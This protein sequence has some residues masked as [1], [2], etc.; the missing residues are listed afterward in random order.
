L[1]APPLARIRPRLLYG[2]CG[3]SLLVVDPE[4]RVSGGLTGWYFRQ[5]RFLSA[6]ALELNGAR[7]YF[8]S[9]AEAAP[10][11]LELAYI[12]P[13][14][15]KGGGGGSGSGASGAR[16]GLL[17]RNLDVRLGFEL[18][19][20]SLDV[21]LCITS[22]WQDVEALEV[23]WFLGADYATVDEAHFAYRDRELH[24]TEEPME[25]GMLFR[26]RDPRFPLETQVVGSGT[27]WRH[28]RARL[29]AELSLA[30]QQ[31]VEL[32]LHA[33]AH[34]ET[35]PLSQT[36][37]VRREARV[38]AWRA[39]VTRVQAPA[40]PPLLEFTERAFDDLGSL[41]LLEGRDDEWMTPGAGVPLYLSLWGRDALTAAWQASVFDRAELLGDALNKLQR[42]QGRVLDSRRDEQPGRIL[43]QGKM[44]AFSRITNAP[45]ARSYADFA[46]PFDFIIGLGY[47]W[48]LTNDLEALTP[49]FRAA[50]RVLDW[51]DQHG[52]RD[53][54]GYLEYLTRAP[55][56]PT[57]QGW[58][59]SE[60]A[61]V[62]EAGGQVSPPIAPCEIQGYW[63]AA[64]QIM[65][66]LSAR[67]G[68][69]AS[70][71]E[72][73]RRATDLKE[74]FNRDFWM[75]DEGFLAFG[76]DAEKRPIR[77]I[78]SN[79]GQCL[80]TGIVSDEH[81]SRLVRRLFA[82]DLFSGWGIRTLSNQNPAYNPLDYH[83]GSVWPVE[84]GT[85]LFG[86][87]RYGLSEQTEQ[88]AR[89]LYD[90]GRL[91]PGGRVPECVGGYGKEEF[92]HPGVY[93]RANAPQTWNQSVFPLLLQSL[94]GLVPFAPLRLLL[95]DPQLPSWLP[96]I[97]LRGLRVGD[98]V[99]DLR[100]RRASGGETRHQVLRKSGKVRVLRQ[101]WVQSFS[102]DS[103]QR[104]HD[105]VET[106]R[107]RR[108]YANRGG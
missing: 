55:D 5:T 74:R 44:D 35:E 40:E 32:R 93:P 86:L 75:E 47:R 92:A 28:G 69:R 51:A 73:W 82:P 68:E 107:A 46:S 58:K 27:R 103:W 89:A 70:A 63:Y 7:P 34:D 23:A 20:A 76:L 3:S 57:H 105:L 91:W 15:E 59:D 8:C 36:D 79:P 66:A 11:K 19:P 1:N 106:V 60:N 50:Q 85:I 24:V 99:V 78:T 18:H 96:D 13:P 53:G 101:A 81:V 6:L 77:A 10:G 95:I 62:D 12:F 104:A 80:A 54:D 37:E 29:S 48:A 56:G 30:R 72:L 67:R 94:L 108:R 38:R 16:D 41:A 98:A 61:I 17:F 21:V 97:T 52:D 71:L 42:L 83:L 4:G 100:F 14:V 43:N 65:A 102:A 49:H 33:R 84:N 45:Y 90:L 87:R 9:A 25:S 2:W 88:L 64:L 39:G 22:R 31:T 26:S